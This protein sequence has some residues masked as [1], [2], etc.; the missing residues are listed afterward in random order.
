MTA[1]WRAN[2][3]WLAALPLGAA[4]LIGGSS[5][6][7]HDYWYIQGLHHE[8]AAGDQ[9]DFVQATDD[10][11]D[12]VGPTSRTFRVRLA[13]VEPTGT[14]LYDLFDDGPRPVGDGQQALVV[15]LDWQADPDQ[16]LTLCTIALVDTQGRRYEQVGNAQPD[17]CV[18]EG[19]GGPEPADSDDPVREV[20]R[21]E[22]RPPSWSTAPEFLV[23]AGVEVRQVLLW[24]EQPDH[25]SL[26]VS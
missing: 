9:G 11:R 1:W 20:P 25:V 5:Y 12:A 6:L 26:S 15:H 10:Y 24:W 19:H 22:D 17:P 18:P 14:Y 23:P 13:G 3:W 4:T 7:V 8:L 2:R 21:G 16:S